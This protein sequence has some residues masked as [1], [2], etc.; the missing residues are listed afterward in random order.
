[1]SLWVSVCVCVCVCYFNCKEA[2]LNKITRKAL[3]SCVGIYAVILICHIVVYVH[4]YVCICIYVCVCL[5]VLCIYVYAL[6]S[7]LIQEECSIY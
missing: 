1:M 3:K 4:V 5:C 2:K 7:L 6:K